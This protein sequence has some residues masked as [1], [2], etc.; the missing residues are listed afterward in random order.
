[1]RICICGGGGLGHT[2]AGVLSSH[3]DVEVSLYTNPSIEHR[4]VQK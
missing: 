2:C 4:Y 3:K 1:M